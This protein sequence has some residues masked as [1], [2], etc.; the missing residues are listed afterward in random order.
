[1]RLPRLNTL[2]VSVPWNL[3]LISGG[4]CLYAVGAMGLARPQGF[5]SGGI[6]GTGMLIYYATDR[7]SISFWYFL[8]NLPLFLLGWHF[9]SRRFLLY[10]L[11]GFTATTLVTGLIS[12]QYH[13]DDPLLAAVAAGTL[14]GAG[15][16][17]VIRSLGSDGGLTIVSII[18]FQKYNFRMGQT[19]FIYN[20]ALFGAGLT[21]LDLN[22]V[23]YSLIF[24]FLTSVVMDYFASMFNHRKMALIVSEKH[25]EIANAILRRLKRGATFIPVRGAFS[26]KESFMVMTVLQ[27]YQLKR[28]EELVFELDEQAF[29]IVENS[30]NVLG[31]GFSKRKV[32]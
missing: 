6:F 11:F 3:F 16:G 22:K 1:M 31:K 14:C 32:Y 25:E 19:S 28:L 12:F 18:L 2:T 29:V 26:G 23:M 9:L 27:N 4:V 15:M 8:L 5:I 30:F 24:I 7:F 21:V 10:T 17:M 20:L 13:F